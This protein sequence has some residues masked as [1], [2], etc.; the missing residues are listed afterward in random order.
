MVNLRIP[1]FGADALFQFVFWDDQLIDCVPI[2][3]ELCAQF[4]GFGAEAVPARFAKPAPVPTLGWLFASERV[5]MNA[6]MEDCSGVMPNVVFCCSGWIRWD[7]QCPRQRC[8]LS[9]GLVCTGARD[10]PDDANPTGFAPLELNLLVAR[11]ARRQ[12][13]GVGTTFV[14]ACICGNTQ[15]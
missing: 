13:A 7:L 10:A 2:D 12:A 6:A 3:V 1:G 4:D 11:R 15:R 5:A 9:A 8:R 14:S